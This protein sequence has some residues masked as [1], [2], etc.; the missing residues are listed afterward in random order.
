MSNTQDKMLQLNANQALMNSYKARCS[1]KLAVTERQINDAKAKREEVRT[2]LNT[3]LN[4]DRTSEDARKDIIEELN[5]WLKH[6]LELL[7]IHEK[8]AKNRLSISQ[9]IDAYLNSK[10]D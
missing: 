7:E 5:K 8:L 9:Q 6:D 3:I 1:Q 2:E 4:S 10:I